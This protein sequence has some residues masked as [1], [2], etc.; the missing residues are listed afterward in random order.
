MALGAK[1]GTSGVYTT[2]DDFKNGKL[3]VADPGT[4]GYN[5]NNH[6]IAISVNG[7]K[8]KFESKKIWGFLLDDELY[9]IIPSVQNVPLP[10][11]LTEAG[12]FCLFIYSESYMVQ[13]S[14]GLQDRNNSLTF[15]S[16]GLNGTTF[17]MW[18]EKQLEKAVAAQKE[19]KALLDCIKK[20][21]INMMNPFTYALTNCMEAQPS[22]IKN[23]KSVVPAVKK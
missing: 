17:G 6:N 14:G 3:Q 12:D 1:A 16:Y 2:F 5:S 20:Q 23:P 13:G 4:F 11:K 7:T 22:Y 8:L 21:K 10:C 18:N 19:L 9:R 15:L